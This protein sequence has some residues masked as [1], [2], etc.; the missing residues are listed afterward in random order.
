VDPGVD[1]QLLSSF[2]SILYNSRVAD[3]LGRVDSIV[4]YQATQSL[5]F[6]VILIHRNFVHCREADVSAIPFSFHH[7]DTTLTSID[8]L[9]VS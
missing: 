3:V 7:P 8:I 4:I 2:P 6:V 9:D 1:G 5:I